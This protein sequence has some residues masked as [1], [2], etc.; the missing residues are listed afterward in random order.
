MNPPPSILLSQSEFNIP[1]TLDIASKCS[2]LTGSNVHDICKLAAHRAASSNN[3][4]F[5]ITPTHLYEAIQDLHPSFE[6]L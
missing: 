6:I 2:G 3:N 4:T 1:N 5:T